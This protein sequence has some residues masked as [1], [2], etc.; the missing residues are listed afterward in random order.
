MK[1]IVACSIVYA[2][3]ALTSIIEIFIRIHYCIG[4]GADYDLLEKIKLP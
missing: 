3:L 4:V 2:I 1:N